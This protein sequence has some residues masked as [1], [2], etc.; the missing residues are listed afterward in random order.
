MSAVLAGRRT[1]SSVLRFVS[2]SRTATRTCRGFAGGCVRNAA[3]EI[4]GEVD[5]F[6]VN[7]FSRTVAA[8]VVRWVGQPEHGCSVVP[9]TTVTATVN[10]AARTVDVEVA[11]GGAAW[12]REPFDSDRY[13]AFSD[14]DLLTALFGSVEPASLRPAAIA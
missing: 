12:P 1:S 4:V 9:F 7:P 2:L 13:P 11:A 3:V 8:V 10:S 14:E 6:L 5:G